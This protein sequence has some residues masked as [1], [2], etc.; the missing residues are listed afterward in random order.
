MPMNTSLYTDVHRQRLIMAAFRLGLSM[1]SHGQDSPRRSQ[2]SSHPSLVQ[3]KTL[4]VA[5]PGPPRSIHPGTDWWQEGSRLRNSWELA[6]CCETA[7]QWPCQWRAPT[8]TTVMHDED[9]QQA[10]RRKEPDPEPLCAG[11]GRAHVVL[12]KV[13]RKRVE[14]VGVDL[15]LRRRACAVKRCAHS[16]CMRGAL[17]LRRACPASCAPAPPRILFQEPLRHACAGRTSETQ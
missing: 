2:R 7:T 9:G 17:R 1:Q 11:C 6:A 4:P 3:T 10:P 14:E 13:V 12:I 5:C 8:R 16:M 15:H